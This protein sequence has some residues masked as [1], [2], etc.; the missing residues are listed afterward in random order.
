M[1]RTNMLAV[2]LLVLATMAPAEPPECLSVTR[3]L[4]LD[5]AGGPKRL[6]LNHP[7]GEVRI[8]AGDSHRLV[9]QARLRNP[10]PGDNEAAI[11]LEIRPQNGKI[12]LNTRSSERVIDL[13][14]RMPGSWA[15]RLD[16]GDRGDVFVHGIRGEAEIQ[17]RW[18]D[19]HLE[20]MAGPVLGHTVEGNLD[21]AFTAVPADAAMVLISVSGRVTVSIPGS[22]S[23]RVRMRGRGG[24]V[25]SDFPLRETASGWREAQLGTDGPL[26]RLESLENLVSL[27]RSIPGR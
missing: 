27:R 3:T 6:L 25:Q 21:A 2:I 15:L 18:G 19:V 24:N 7:K 17:S 11:G 23:A 5:Q 26:I 10:A 4:T 14:I 8:S 12:R 13:D 1:M 9:V 20:A 22:A 16:H